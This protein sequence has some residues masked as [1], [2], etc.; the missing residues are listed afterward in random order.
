METKTAFMTAGG[1]GIARTTIDLPY[2]DATAP[3][4]DAL[5]TRRGVLLGSSY[6]YPGRYARYDVAF[7]DPP[8]CI[9]ARGRETRVAALNERGCVLL[10]PIAEA[11]RATPAVAEVAYEGAGRDAAAITVQLVAAA[12]D[13]PEEERSKQPSVF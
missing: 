2:G 8:V 10:P 13:F 1:I 11:L 9:E 4:L 12:L 6:E 5:D 7:A 3:V